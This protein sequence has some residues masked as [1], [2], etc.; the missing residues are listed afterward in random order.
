MKI[1]LKSASFWVLFTLFI[2]ILLD[3][4]YSVIYLKTPANRSIVQIAL[5]TKNQHFDYIVLGSSRSNH[6]VN[7]P[8]IDK[9]LRLNGFNFSYPG[10]KSDEILSLLKILIKNKNSI[11][12]VFIQI[13]NLHNTFDQ[14]LPDSFALQA[15]LPFIYHQDIWKHYYQ[16]SKLRPYLFIPFYR[17]AMNRP[18]IGEREVLMTLMKRKGEHKKGYIPLKAPKIYRSNMQA[19]YPKPLMRHNKNFAK[20]IE[21]C[22]KYHIDYHF[23]TA[24]LYRFDNS[25]NQPFH[26]I[27]K[28]KYTDFSTTIQGDTCFRDADHLNFRGADQFTRLLIKDLF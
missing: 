22:K 13:D 28:E 11:N 6:T 27:F 19:K 4:T 26:E 7:T 14:S 18:S 25:V 3:V 20:L 12:K 8:L 15:F 1:F 21:L 9:T 17:Y 5:F 24:P 16:Y 2:A 10:V 23:F